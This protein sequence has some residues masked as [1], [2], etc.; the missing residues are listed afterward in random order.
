MTMAHLIGSEET[1][2]L[3]LMIGYSWDQHGSTLEVTQQPCQVGE[4]P[5]RYSPALCRICQASMAETQVPRPL[6]YQ[7]CGR[8]P[9]EPTFA[10]LEVL[11][12]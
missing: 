9:V 7:T 1:Q 3:V 2:I 12:T 5:K 6:D 10:V 8:T 11:G 4:I